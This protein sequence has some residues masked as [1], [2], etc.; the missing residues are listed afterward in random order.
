MQHRRRVVWSSGSGPSTSPSRASKV[1][2]HGHRT[3]AGHAI[4]VKQSAPDAGG[5][6]DS[7]YC[8]A[9]AMRLQRFGVLDPT[10][11]LG[12]G[13]VWKAT[14]TPEGPGTL[15]LGWDGQRIEARAWGPGASWLLT[16]A[17]A[18]CAILDAP[19]RLRPQHAWL[20]SL[21]RRH[22]HVAL[23]QAPR[24]F[25]TLV[26]YIL[27]QRVA[28][29]DAARSWRTIV[30]AFGDEAPGPRGFRLPLTP[31]QWS[32]ISLPKLVSLGVD[33]QRS[34]FIREAALQARKIERVDGAPIE[35]ARDLIPKLRG[36]GPWTA[37]MVLAV[38][39]GDPDAVPLGD[40]AMP[41]IVARAFTGQPRGDDATMLR[42]LAPY[43]G[44]RFRVLRL[45]FAGSVRR[46]KFGPRRARRD[47]RI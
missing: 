43:A 5:R 30:Q 37:G 26:S 28:F 7:R 12:H 47:A 15:H 41:S 38:G 21:V 22:P 29:V 34:R 3:S 32:S 16:R 1:E 40:F 20:E 33:A 27:Q 24:L 45:L 17:P 35:R 9:E 44:Q 13:E 39:R 8:P 14:H 6:F 10:M 19:E 23:G 4:E 31:D 11:E 25:D 42:L 18:Y 36:L 2:S 46:P